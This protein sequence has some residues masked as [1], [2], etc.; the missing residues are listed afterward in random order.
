MINIKLHSIV[1]LI[2]NSSTEIF[3]VSDDNGEHFIKEL[4]RKEASKYDDL[5]WFENDV[6]I[7]TND[8]GSIEIYS[9]INDPE[10]FNEFMYKNFNV[11]NFENWG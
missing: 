10:W 11:T 4:L 6:N 2:T 5:E 1:D 8:D 7:T 9:S 3:T